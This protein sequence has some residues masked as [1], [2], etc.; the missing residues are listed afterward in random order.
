MGLF[1]A[2]GARVS[3]SAD[4]YERILEPREMPPKDCQPLYHAIC[5]S[6]S[7]AAS[8]TRSSGELA[9]LRCRDNES[10]AVRIQ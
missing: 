10:T 3:K 6:N 1:P 7:A 2:D 5:S 4:Q 8:R 9:R